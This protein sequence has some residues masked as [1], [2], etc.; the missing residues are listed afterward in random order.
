[1]DKKANTE[2]IK[3]YMNLLF[4]PLEH[5]NLP[6][7][8]G[9]KSLSTALK[10]AGGLAVGMGTLGVLARKLQAAKEKAERK[11]SDNKIKAYVQSKNPVLSL[12][13]STRDPVRE[14]K[15]KEL[16]TKGLDSTILKEAKVNPFSNPKVHAMAPGLAALA[17]LGGAYGG[18]RLADNAE[19]KKLESE[20]DEDVAERENQIDKLLLQEYLRKREKV[21][22]ADKQKGQGLFNNVKSMY[23]LYALLTMA[24]GYKASRSFFDAKDPNR[25]RMKELKKVMEE[26]GRVEGTPQ[27]A[28][29]SK[30]P[31]QTAPTR[32][33]QSSV[34]I[35]KKEE[36]KNPGSRDVPVDQD[37]PY[38]NLLGG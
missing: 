35:Q 29:L 16:G 38:A 15:L 7:A 34:E 26:K 14:R 9:D 28:D 31:E 30:L 5:Q 8:E 27:F 12:D 21:A 2:K 18:Y 23:M 22:S 19:D 13:D 25:Q 4:N 3:Q 37:D 10:H 11:E 32:K 36:S 20:I 17:A 24:G 33:K 1:M 6:R